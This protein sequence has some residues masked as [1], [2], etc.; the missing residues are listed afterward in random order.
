[1]E[2]LPC[3]VKSFCDYR[4]A[5]ISHMCKF[6]LSTTNHNCNRSC[7]THGLVSGHMIRVCPDNYWSRNMNIFSLI[8][9]WKY[10]N[11]CS[12]CN[13][14]IWYINNGFRA[15][16][17]LRA[18]CSLIQRFKLLNRTQFDFH[19]KSVTKAMKK[20]ITSL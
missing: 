1:M 16:N 9:I 4:M 5:W 18:N 8:F 20:H 3:I 14:Q 15:I 2:K 6:G 19:K 17:F 13:L 7:Q 10:V 11:I 12:K